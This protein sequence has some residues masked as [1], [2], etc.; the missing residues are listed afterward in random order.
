MATRSPRKNS[1]TLFAGE[2]NSMTQFA[3]VSQLLSLSAQEYYLSVQGC[4]LWKAKEMVNTAATLQTLWTL[5]RGT[6]L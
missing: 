1:T 5:R 2:K 4:H 3:G 6:A